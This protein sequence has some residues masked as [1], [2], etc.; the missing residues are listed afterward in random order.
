[1]KYVQYKPDILE[2]S[3]RLDFLVIILI[4]SVYFTILSNVTVAVFCY[5]MLA[6]V[7]LYL[8]STRR[9]T[10]S[11]TKFEKLFLFFIAASFVWV[12][13]T[14]FIN[15]MPEKGG[16]WIIRRQLN[17]LMVIPIY[18][19][20][21]G[22]PIPPNVWWLA[23]S[24][25]AS[26]VG[27]VAVFEVDWSQGWP[28]GRARGDTNR[29][30]FGEISLCLVFITIIGVK[31]FFLSNKLKV[32]FW[33][34]SVFL[35]GLAVVLSSARGAWIPIPFL[36]V[37]SFW[38]L[39]KNVSVYKKILILVGLIAIPIMM[40]QFPYTQAK[41][42]QAEEQLSNY[43]QRGTIVDSM[44]DSS[45]GLRLEAWRLMTITIHE[46]PLVGIG[47]GGFKN[48]IKH[49]INEGITHPSI[50]LLSHSHNQYVEVAVYSGLIGLL[51]Y[52][53]ILL[54]PGAIFLGCIKNGTSQNSPYAVSGLLIILAFLMFGMTDLTLAREV[55]A[56]FYGLSIS[57]L[58]SLVN[59][60]K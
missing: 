1:M 4:F 18:L 54:V 23:I 16:G 45:I 36:I 57:I 46:N 49:Y 38:Y 59:Q 56:M 39:S 24:I 26:I 17:V 6:L 47:I 30:F 21:R 40:F 37:I 27:L 41:Y 58:L 31:T 28:M 22:R 55:P 53:G 32:I 19:M 5:S 3:K 10:L 35:G 60:K 29:I 2:K 48:E 9:I 50:S 34:S 15:G 33:F 51:F 43:F 25:G 7:A 12:S 8:I 20:L 52:L 42:H 13:I 11:L 44:Q 14:Y